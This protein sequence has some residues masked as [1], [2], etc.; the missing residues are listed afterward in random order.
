MEA[1]IGELYIF[2]IVKYMWVIYMKLV[3]KITIE[4]EN[5]DAIKNIILEKD[6]YKALKKIEELRE[7]G[8]LSIEKIEMSEKR[9]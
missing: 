7:S 9:K 4:T 2:Y 3:L 1:E 8:L 5:R 6:F